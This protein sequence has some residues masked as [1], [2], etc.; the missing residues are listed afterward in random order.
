MMHH[1]RRHVTTRLAS[2]GLVLPVRHVFDKRR[3]Q[4]KEELENAGGGTFASLRVDGWRDK[5]GWGPRRVAVGPRIE[6][7]AV[8]LTAL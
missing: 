4:T 5:T 3:A 8:F 6:T 7:L 2:G 1:Q